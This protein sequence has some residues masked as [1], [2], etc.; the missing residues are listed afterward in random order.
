MDLNKTVSVSNYKEA[1]A[2]ETGTF[3]AI[4]GNSIVCLSVNKGKVHEAPAIPLQAVRGSAGSE[5][6]LTKISTTPL[7]VETAASASAT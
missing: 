1:V 7:Q 6:T 2:H 5:W 3:V 4:S